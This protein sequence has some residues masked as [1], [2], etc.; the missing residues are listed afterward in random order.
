[1]SIISLSSGGDLP[2]SRC[3]YSSRGGGGGDDT[4]NKGWWLGDVH[5]HKHTPCNEE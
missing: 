3:Q 2:L 1:M 5:S 4:E